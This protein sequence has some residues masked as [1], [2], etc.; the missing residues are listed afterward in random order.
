ME[1]P[2]GD[3]EIL[4]RGLDVEDASTGRHPLGRPVGDEATTSLGVLVGEGP[5]DHVGHRLEP[6]MR[7]P[8]GSLR[9]TRGV[10][11]FAHLVHVDERVQVVQAHPGE[12]R[13]VIDGHSR[14]RG[15]LSICSPG[16]R[17]VAEL[18]SHPPSLCRRR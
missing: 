15:L 10:V 6:A 1:Q 4:G 2:T 5:V 11:D 7:V 12:R 16:V 9:L 14:H 18:R 3:D 13:Q 17:R 8:R